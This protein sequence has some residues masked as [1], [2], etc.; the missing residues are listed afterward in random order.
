MSLTKCLLIVLLLTAFAFPQAGP[1]KTKKKAAAATT[2][3]ASDTKPVARPKS[4]DI[5]AMDKTV[6]PCD[7]FYEYA[8]GNWRKNN[9]IPPD[10]ARWGRFNELAEYNRQILHQILEK[11]SANN[12]KRNPVQQKIGDMYESC[13]DE[14]AVNAKGSTP[15]K[16]ELAR[17]AAISNKDQLMSTVAYLHSRGVPAL[18]NFGSQPD[19]HNASM[20][21][22]N[23]FQGG[24]GLPDRD[25]YLGQDDK[26]KET[27][28][29]YLEH[30]TTMFTLLGD[31]PEAAKKEAQT[32]MDIETKLADA[33]M[34]RVKMRDPK[35]RDHKMPVTELNKL[36]PNFEFARF[37]TDT[38]APS[39]TDVNVVPPDFFQKVN[40]VIDSVPIA[41]WKTY[42]R[43]HVVDAAAPMLSDKFVDANFEFFG[44]FLSGQKELQARWKRCVQTTDRL[45]GEALG[46]P[47]VDETFGQEGK[48][49]ML[50][51]VKELE[52]ALG[53]DIQSLDWMTPETK[54]KAEAKL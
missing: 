23:I 44:K 22:A 35:S 45:L 16:P 13:M 52:A 31:A 5:D 41:D 51:M 49:R 10:Q 1:K 40:P 2:A 42:L 50:Q 24:L 9:P 54:K 3:A 14:K 12:P 43:W 27:R 33:A 11:D 32:V 4:F 25:Y 36:A 28:E 17:I 20:M 15:I 48:D 38:G 29:K 39:F 46:Q 19:L 8:C 7:D 26:S 18:F 6:N 30:V 37:F 34:E 21:V 53:D 47:Y